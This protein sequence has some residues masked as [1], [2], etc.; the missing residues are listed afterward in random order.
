MNAKVEGGVSLVKKRKQQLD[1]RVKEKCM[2][3]KD[4]EGI[5]CRERK[6]SRRDEVKV[7]P[8]AVSASAVL[9]AAEKLTLCTLMCQR[10]SH[11]FGNSTHPNAATISS[12][13]ELITWAIL[14]ERR[15]GFLG[16]LRTVLWRSRDTR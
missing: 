9:C 14:L 10:L 6:G 13:Q 1:S 11:A 2:W 5:Q 16:R 12:Q 8:K 15:K 7:R 4:L 3:R